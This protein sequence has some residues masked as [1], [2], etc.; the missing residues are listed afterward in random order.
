MFLPT[1]TFFIFH[2]RLS[3]SDAC[4]SLLGVNVAED[5]LATDRKS[6]ASFFDRCVLIERCSLLAVTK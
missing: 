3:D 5:A 1:V 6:A 2:V 4:V